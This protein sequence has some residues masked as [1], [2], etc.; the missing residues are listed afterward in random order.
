MVLIMMVFLNEVV[1]LW[2]NVAPY[3]LL[4]IVIAGIL[5]IFMGKDFIT[6]HLGKPGFASILKATIFGVPLPVCS[7]GVIPLASSLKKDGAN[8]SSVLA[9]LVSTPTSGVDSIL[10][11]FSLMGLLFAAFRLIG[12]F[13]AGLT[14]GITDYLFG[15][16]NKQESYMA[17]HSHPEITAGMKIREFFYYTFRE[18]PRDIG[19]WL[20]VGTIFGG[21]IAAFVP[22][23]FFSGYLGF[24]LDFIVALLVGIP[25]YVCATGSIPIA[26]SLIMKGFSPGAGLVFLIVGPATNAITLSFVRAKLGK[27]SFY[28]YLISIVVTAV[29]LG[30]F[31]NGIWAAL[32]KNVSLV[33]GHGKIIPYWIKLGSG[34]VLLSL[35]AST[36]LNRGS[37]MEKPDMELGVPDLHCK[38]CKIKVENSLRGIDGLEKVSIDIE[39]KVVQIK[40]SVNRKEVLDKIKEAGY[41]PTTKTDRLK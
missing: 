2:L 3:L 14:V 9:F 8:T 6:R 31:F 38:S 35:I 15:S 20:L 13:V 1:K 21:A 29:V 23:D 17:D 5:H 30:L 39:N 40:G 24:P 16:E 34:I 27:K 33:A 18:I 11:T 28:L 25:M 41:N 32:G 19:K 37:R 10:A 22:A 26:A 36:F 4:G 12:A 7:C